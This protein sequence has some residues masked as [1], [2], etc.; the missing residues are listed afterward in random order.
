M[1]VAYETNITKAET[2]RNL[3]YLVFHT[4]IGK[5]SAPNSS[6]P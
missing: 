3:Q 5:T 6:E 2:L 4:E 1:A